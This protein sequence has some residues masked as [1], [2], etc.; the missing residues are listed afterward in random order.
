MTSSCRVMLFHESCDFYS[1]SVRWAYDSTA[2]RLALG[3]ICS[4]W[5]QPQTDSW[6]TVFATHLSPAL[7]PGFVPGF[8]QLL[9]KRHTGNEPH[10]GFPLM[11][12]GHA[13]ERRLFLHL[14]L[15]LLFSSCSPTPAGGTESSLVPP[16]PTACERGAHGGV[17]GKVSQAEDGNSS[18]PWATR[19]RSVKQAYVPP[20]TVKFLHLSASSACSWVFF[21]S[22]FCTYK[23]ELIK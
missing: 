21:S 9:N 10:P 16:S 22:S 20:G 5:F 7:C 19:F 1:F 12:D 14:F 8:K 17:Q 3:V 6:P 23:T 13:E 15:T 4:A 2:N 11:R 18:F